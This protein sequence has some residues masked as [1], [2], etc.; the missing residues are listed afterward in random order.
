[1]QIL[2]VEDDLRLGKMMRLLLMKQNNVVTWL[3]SGEDAIDYAATNRYDI[4]LLDWMLPDVQGID[5]LKQLR[6][7]HIT[8]PIIMMTAK[9]ELEDKISGFE[10]GA[11]DYIVK[12][13]EF[14]E[15]NMRINALHRRSVGQVTSILEVGPISVDTIKQRVRIRNNDINLTHK[16]YTLL[17]LL[18][19]YEGIVPKDMILDKVWS[20]DEIVSDNNVETLIKRLRQKLGT[21]IQPYKIKAVRNMGYTLT[22]DPS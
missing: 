20:I 8:T 1:M 12:P 16:E 14:E 13:F 21:D 18:M 4:I 22:H 3:T 15:L 19:E 10:T 7:Q 2:L 5:I 17:V 9:G 11:D 6:E